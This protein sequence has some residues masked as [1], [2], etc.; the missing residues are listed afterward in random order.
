LICKNSINLSNVQ[1]PVQNEVSKTMIVYLVYNVAF[2]YYFPLIRYN[3]FTTVAV[4]G[5]TYFS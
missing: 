5:M 3:L 4:F 1:E 2:I